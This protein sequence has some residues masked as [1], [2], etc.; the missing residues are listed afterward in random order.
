MD[1]VRRD[2]VSAEK[3]SGICADCTFKYTCK[4]GCRAFAYDEF[5]DLQAPHPLCD[6]LDKRGEF[7]SI[8]R[9]SVKQKLMGGRRLP[10]LP[11]QP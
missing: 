2:Y 11:V 1:I 4:G 6:A 8:Y 5:G 3:L 7:P 9:I 10:T